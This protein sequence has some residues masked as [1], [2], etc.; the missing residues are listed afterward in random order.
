[1]TGRFSFLLVLVAVLVVPG[2]VA[3]QGACSVTDTIACD[4]AVQGTLSADGETDCFTFAGLANDIVSLAVQELSAGFNACWE[5]R[6]STGAVVEFTCGEQKHATLPVNDTYTIAVYDLGDDDIGTYGLGFTV[7][8]SS[9][10][11]CA[12]PITCG[13]TLPRSISAI[14]ES[15]TFTFPALAGEV[16]SITIQQTVGL[17]A[18]WELYRPSGGSLANSCDQKSVTLPDTGSYIIRAFDNG[19]DDSGNYNLNLVFVSP[20]V[21]SCSTA[22]TCG[23]MLAGNIDE[24]AESETYGFTTTFPNE[25]VRVTTVGALN[26]FNACWSLYTP[27]G[28]PVPDA[29][30]VCAAGADILLADAGTHTIRVADDLDNATGGY[31]VDLACLGTPTPTPTPTPTETETPTPTVTQTPLDTPTLTATP[32]VSATPTGETPTPTDAPTATS[33][34]PTPTPSVTP[35]PTETIPPTATPTVPRTATPVVTPTAA[36]GGLANPVAAKAAA[37]CQK[38]ITTASAK[39]AVGRLKRLDGCAARILDCFEAKPGDATC[40]DKASVAC[41]KGLAKLAD[42]EAKMRGSILKSCGTLAFGDLTSALGLGFEGAVGAC[43]AV[44][45]PLVDLGSLIACATE[46]HACSADA[47]QTAAAPRTG[48]LYRLLSIVVP[49]GDCLEDFGGGG[50]EVGDPKLGKQVVKCARGITGAARTLASKRLS[51]VA[52]CVNAVMACLQTEPN[53]GVCLAKA[54]ARCGANGAK[55]LAAEAKFG[56]TVAKKCGAIAF[57]TLAAGAGLN[58]GA[59]D[60][61]CAPL[62]AGPVGSLASFQECVRRAYACGVADLIEAEAPRAAQVLSLVGRSLHDAFCPP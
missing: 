57:S 48:E 20:T 49:G 38:T 22:I 14:A 6:R 60:A 39:L 41:A 53:D 16:A 47:L 44:G 42:D 34:T 58:L 21:S 52:G 5:V 31:T 43:A 4:E 51:G 35:S 50:A 36:P 2:R 25:T 18:C 9:A 56:S 3:A 28:D 1:V 55:I 40:R 24:I 59:L 13:D 19:D 15:D 26:P 12:A 11:S 45:S 33:E 37:K 29:T 54:N 17:N 8:S 46:R 27:L 30:P 10:S 32:T 7:V 61:T 23:Q 62:G